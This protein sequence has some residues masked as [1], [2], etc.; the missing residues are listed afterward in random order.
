[1]DRPARLA[2]AAS[3][4]IGT[5]FRLQGRNPACGLD[6]IGL[7]LASLAEVGIKVA[8]PADY[9]ARRRSFAIPRDALLAAGL[10]EAT[11]RPRAGDLLL[12]QTGPVQAHAAVSLTPGEIIHAHASLKR[13]VRSPLP[14][15]WAVLAIWR[16][17]PKPVPKGDTSWQ[18]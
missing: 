16:I 5:P 18:R 7:V 6:C 1:M 3:G 11:G 10:V 2:A 4:F 17:A 8:L 15:S 9:R 13:V 14:D 12:L